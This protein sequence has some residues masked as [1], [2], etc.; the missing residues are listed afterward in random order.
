MDTVPISG[1]GVGGGGARSP[2]GGGHLGEDD[3]QPREKVL[4]EVMTVFASD[5]QLILHDRMANPKDE[6]TGLPLIPVSVVV[7]Y[8]FFMKPFDQS[9]IDGGG[10][11]DGGAF[12]LPGRSSTL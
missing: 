6:A 1:S 11:I 8:L 7:P 12:P 10:M 5:N 4:G 9:A 3:D 2:G